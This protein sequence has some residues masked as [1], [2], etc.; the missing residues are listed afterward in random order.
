MSVK[1]RVTV[2]PI[3][4]EERV[5]RGNSSDV[6]RKCNGAKVRTVY[7]Q[8]YVGMKVLQKNGLL[9]ECVDYI[10]SRDTVVKVGEQTLH[11]C[12]KQFLDGTIGR[13]ALIQSRVGVKSVQNFGRTAVVEEYIDNVNTKVLFENGVRLTV[14]WRDFYAGTIGVVAY[15]K[16]LKRN[17]LKFDIEMRVFQ[18]NVGMYAKCIDYDINADHF[19]YEF[20]DGTKIASTWVEFLR[21][22]LPYGNNYL[23]IGKLIKLNDGNILEVL[24]TS[25]DSKSTVR[26]VKTGT[27]YSS[28]SN[29]RLVA[30]NFNYNEGVSCGEVYKFCNKNE[31]YRLVE[32]TADYICI[33]FKSY[34]I[35]YKREAG[36]LTSM[37][38]P[39]TMS[40]RHGFRLL[41]FV[42][43][44]PYYWNKSVG[45]LSFNDMYSYL[46][47]KGFTRRKLEVIR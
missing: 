4:K 24:S 22:E 33:Q 12:V 47:T 32:Y 21:G 13:R 29:R 28:I 14:K 17:N 44:I 25:K 23:F 8:K 16:E 34:K 1:T 42:D 5:V 19:L 30:G 18:F 11:V 2:C 35:T 31:E 15:I 37:P 10:S 45:I 43:K 36:S 3:C 7:R 38:Y 39:F 46:E 6:C 9:A 20:E 26:D 41:Y 27:L 40:S